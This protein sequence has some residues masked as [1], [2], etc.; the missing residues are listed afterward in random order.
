MSNSDRGIGK[1]RAEHKFWFWA[2]IALIASALG[3]V[4]IYLL[5]RRRRE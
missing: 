3:G 1:F 2:I 5:R 4:I